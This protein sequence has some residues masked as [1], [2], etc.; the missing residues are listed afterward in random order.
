[1]RLNCYSQ[2]KEKTSKQK[3][4][5]FFLRRCAASKFAATCTGPQDETPLLDTPLIEEVTK[6]TLAENQHFHEM[7]LIAS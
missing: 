5:N 4:K 6:R 1:M 2:K 7:S 3:K